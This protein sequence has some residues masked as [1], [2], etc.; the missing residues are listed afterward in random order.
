MNLNEMILPAIEA[1]QMFMIFAL[2]FKIK[3]QE[4][5]ILNLESNQ[6]PVEVRQESKND[7]LERYRKEVQNKK[8]SV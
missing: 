4:N 7:L 8:F 2:L 3:V 6:V 5:R 1:L